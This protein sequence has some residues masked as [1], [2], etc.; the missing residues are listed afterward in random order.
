MVDQIH[1][2]TEEIACLRA[3]VAKLERSDA[4]L[5]ARVEELTKEVG[6]REEMLHKPNKISPNFSLIFSLIFLIIL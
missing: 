4:E 2:A 5:K 3:K 6:K 1:T